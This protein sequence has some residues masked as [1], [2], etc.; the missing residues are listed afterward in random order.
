MELEGSVWSKHSGF[1]HFVDV[2]S[3]VC[4]DLN[5]LLL[6][7]WLLM[8]LLNRLGVM[9]RLVPGLK[10]HVSIVRLV[11]LLR[12][13]RFANDLC[14]LLAGSLSIELIIPLAR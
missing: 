14:L 2:Y 8:M 7:S 13:L 4:V 1:L 5:L 9:L 12:S 11:V 3:V 6:N 10:Q